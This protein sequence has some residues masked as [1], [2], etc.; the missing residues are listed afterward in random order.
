MAAKI[1]PIIIV[2]IYWC[3]VYTAGVIRLIFRAYIILLVSCSSN[4]IVDCFT[5]PVHPVA[6][7][8]WPFFSGLRAGAIESQYHESCSPAYNFQY[9]D[10]S[11]IQFL[12][13]HAHFIF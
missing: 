4:I 8:S 9:I 11:R 7:I 10:F 2:S 3:Q 1:Q 12:S 5:V 13:M 6:E